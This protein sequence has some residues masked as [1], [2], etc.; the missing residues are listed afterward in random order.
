MISTITKKR[1]IRDFDKLGKSFRKKVMKNFPDGFNS[2]SITYLSIQGKTVAAVPFE[3]E[4]TYYLLRLPS[5]TPQVRKKKD[6]HQEN[7]DNDTWQDT[8]S[9]VNDYSKLEDDEPA[10]DNYSYSDYN[11]EENQEEFYD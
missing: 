2:D 6:R 9:E 3:T 4:D 10:D 5:Q 8:H 11:K 1:V 7:G